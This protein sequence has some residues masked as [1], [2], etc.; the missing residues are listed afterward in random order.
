MNEM[1]DEELYRA[2]IDIAEKKI[3][4]FGLSRI[5]ERLAKSNSMEQT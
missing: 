4:K 3:D 1:P 5:F 2:M